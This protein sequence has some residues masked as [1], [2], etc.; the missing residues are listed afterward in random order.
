MYSR[1]KRPLK[2][3]QSY[4]ADDLKYEG[5]VG[6]AEFKLYDL[7][8]R[9]I[10]TYQLRGELGVLRI[11]KSELSSGVYLYLIQDNTSILNQG[12]VVIQH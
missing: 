5:L 8:G 12:K 2:F 4:K 7:T 1:G 6:A 10:E 11:S 9:L 3:I